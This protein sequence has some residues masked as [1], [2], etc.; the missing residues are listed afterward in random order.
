MSCACLPNGIY[1]GLQSSPKT[2]P[3]CTRNSPRCWRG[4]G[5]GKAEEARGSEEL[6]QGLQSPA[7]AQ[8]RTYKS[9]SCTGAMSFAIEEVTHYQN[10]EH[11]GANR[12]GGSQS[13]EPFPTQ[14]EDVLRVDPHM[15]PSIKE[16]ARSAT[17]N[18]LACGWLSLSATGGA[19]GSQPRVG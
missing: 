12:R 17:N 7:E 3:S 11:N 4:L 15:G 10:L 8:L 18:P 9:R 16:G 2:C 19:R 13:T 6:D 5:N 14:S 1:G